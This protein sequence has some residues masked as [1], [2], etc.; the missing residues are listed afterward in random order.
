MVPSSE[1]EQHRQAFR[2]NN[3]KITFSMA[4]VRYYFVCI[5]IRHSGILSLIVDGCHLDLCTLPPSLIRKTFL[6]VSH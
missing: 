4:G 6:E 2:S 5:I 1:P 3:G